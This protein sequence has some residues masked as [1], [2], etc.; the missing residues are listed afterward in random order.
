MRF[1]PIWL[2]LLLVIIATLTAFSFLMDER[3]L[4]MSACQS[5]VTHSIATSQTIS[6]HEVPP[7]IQSE[8]PIATTLSAAGKVSAQHRTVRVFIVVFKDRQRLWKLL[9]RIAESDLIK[10]DY[11]VIIINNYGVLDLPR[12]YRNQSSGVYVSTVIDNLVRPDFSKGHLSRDWNTALLQG[13]QSLIS[14]KSDYVITLQGDALVHRNWITTLIRLHREKNFVLITGGIG[15]ALMSY[16]VEAV[17]MI[18]L[19][20]ERFCNIGY[21]EF[22]YFIRAAIFATANVSINDVI[23]RHV[24]NPIPEPFFDM[25]AGS[26]GGRGDEDHKTSLPFHQYSR[27]ILRAKFPNYHWPNPFPA[28]NVTSVFPRKPAIPSFLLYPYFEQHVYN[29]SDKGFLVPD[30]PNPF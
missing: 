10:Y 1:Q 11:E 17:R 15:D 9:D 4:K 5:N 28:N 22:D 25:E 19:W 26:G 24:L 2:S 29:L 30:D 6:T 23:G 13:F 12:C 14:P 21:Q 8:P 7:T 16:T 3:V 18:G 27:A 20:D